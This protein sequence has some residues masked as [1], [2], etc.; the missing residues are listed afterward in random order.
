[1]RLL[2]VMDVVQ[3]IA[4]AIIFT[5]FVWIFPGY[6]NG[7]KTLGKIDENIKAK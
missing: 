2:D 7:M 3:F 6:S 1:M 5:I 4:E